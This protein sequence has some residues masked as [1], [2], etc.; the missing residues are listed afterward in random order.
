MPFVLTNAPNTLMWL[1]NYILR[2]YLGKHVVYFDDILI[3]S[4]TLHEHRKHVKSVLITLTKEKLYANF[5]KC[6][7]FVEKVNYLGFIVGKNGVEVDEEKVKAIKD[8]PTP[9]KCK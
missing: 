5:N 2:E 9:K 8:W 3:Y 1:M 7:F 4:K 6:S